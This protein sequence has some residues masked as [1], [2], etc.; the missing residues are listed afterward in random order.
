VIRKATIARPTSASISA[1]ATAVYEGPSDYIVATVEPTDD[2]EV[3]KRGTETH[4]HAGEN[5]RGSDPY[6]KSI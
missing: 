3:T 6:R 4:E 1:T 5:H 2:S